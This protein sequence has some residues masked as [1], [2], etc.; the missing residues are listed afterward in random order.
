MLM[1]LG[2]KQLEI[3]LLKKRDFTGKP[4]KL[5]I[6]KEDSFMASIRFHENRFLSGMRKR[7]F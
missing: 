1:E 6:P 3:D 2:R 5:V 7:G 4:W